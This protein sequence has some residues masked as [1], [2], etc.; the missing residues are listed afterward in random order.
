M[1]VEMYPNVPI[2]IT[3][4]SIKTLL[5]T[6]IQDPEKFEI[7]YEGSRKNLHESK[8]FPVPRQQ[9]FGTSL[10][11]LLSPSAANFLMADF[12]QKIKKGTIR[13]PKF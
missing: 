9:N 8:I 11:N 12:E 6:E 1:L 13:F 3:L 7:H 10:G 5:S 4:R 2:E